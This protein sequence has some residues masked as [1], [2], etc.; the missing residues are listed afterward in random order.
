MSRRTEIRYKALVIRAIEPEIAK[1]LWSR[2]SGVNLAV[3]WRRLV[4]LLEEI[5]FYA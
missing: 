3:V 2:R 1:L 5:S 4:F